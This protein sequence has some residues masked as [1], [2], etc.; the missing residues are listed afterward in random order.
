MSRLQV[1]NFQP[2]IANDDTIESEFHNRDRNRFVTYP[3]R[4]SNPQL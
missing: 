3:C 4:V 2:L 1:P